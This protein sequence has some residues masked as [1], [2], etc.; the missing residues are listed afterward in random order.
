M[1]R[2]RSWATAAIAAAIVLTAWQP[3]GASGVPPGYM[4][5]AT[6]RILYSDGLGF[7]TNMCV[8][9]KK[10]ARFGVTVI[11]VYENAAGD[12]LSVP[13][14]T[15]KAE[16][17]TATSSNPGAASVSPPSIS[18][19]KTI[20]RKPGR[21]FT[22]TASNPGHA[23]VTFA[24]A[25]G[26]ATP[27]VYDIDVEHCHYEVSL[28]SRWTIAFGFRPTLHSWFTRAELR[29]GVTGLFFEGTPNM[30]NQATAPAY[31]GCA[32]TYDVLPSGVLMRGVMGTGTNPTL[33]LTFTFQ[34]VEA[35]PWVCADMVENGEGSGTPRVLTFAVDA[36]ARMTSRTVAHKL[37]A[38]GVWNGRTTI[39]VYRVPN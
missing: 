23:T 8:G 6:Q 1:F 4:R 5:V 30:A 31:A 3:P 29:P 18:Q 38:G 10:Q 19:G 25:T 28:D 15:G 16:V 35:T 26:S 21:A 13:R 11:D 27:F 2:W 9:E 34:E 17:I 32:V 20:R 7:P 33:T 12:T 37:D 24:E 14:P 36:T 39:T 22:V